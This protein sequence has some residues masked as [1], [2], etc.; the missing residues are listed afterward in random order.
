MEQQDNLLGVLKT[1]FKWKKQIIR[2]CVVAAI[3]SVIISLFL[4]NYYESSTIFYAASPDLAKPDGIGVN[5]KDKEYYGESED[6]DRVLT[7]AESSKIADFLIKKYNLYSHYDIDSTHRKA[8]YRVRKTFSELYNVVKTKYDGIEIAVE[9]K[10]PLIAMQMVNDAREM[11]DKL[12][13]DLIKNSQL[14]SIGKQKNLLLEQRK[15]LKALGDSLAVLR[16]VY[17]IYNTVS[18][19][20]LL[21]ELLARS[22]SNLTRTQARYNNY[23]SNRNVRRD[24][25]NKLAS[26]ISG[27][28]QEVISLKERMKRFNKG[29]SIIDAMEQEHKEARDQT[30]LD[31]E[32]LKQ[33][34]SAY[35]TPFTSIYLVEAGELPIVKKRPLR[36]VI[37]LASIF[38]AFLFSVIGILLMEAYKDVNW[39]EITNG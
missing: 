22:E 14:Q 35:E 32:R 16:E 37:V 5:E 23:K 29:M 12:G 36:M 27:Y 3:G 6:M 8:P 20:E 13:Q 24:T 28:E 39:K 10:D 26:N 1:L 38:V 4:P 30:G 15:N 18:Q 7:L 21:A 9:D 2:I 25:L 33:F 11:V 34:Q 17:G 19:S 31:N